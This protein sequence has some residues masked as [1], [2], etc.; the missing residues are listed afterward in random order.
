M[1]YI[2]SDKS[3]KLVTY[4]AYFFGALGN[5]AVVP[6]LVKAWQGPSPGLAISTWILFTIVGANWMIY[7]IINKQKPLLVTTSVGLCLNVVLITGW[8]IHN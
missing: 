7:S 1:K 4:S 5:L 6:Q 8:I 3:K 2:S